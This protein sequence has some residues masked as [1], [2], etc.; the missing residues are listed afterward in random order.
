M[1][2]A[3]SLKTKLNNELPDLGG[4]GLKSSKIDILVQEGKHN[5]KD[6]IDK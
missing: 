5:T 6:E 2:I 4:E 3:L 1:T